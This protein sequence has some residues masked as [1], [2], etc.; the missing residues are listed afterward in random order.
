M[1]ELNGFL[2]GDKIQ[3][4]ERIPDSDSNYFSVAPGIGWSNER[5]QTLLAY[6]RILTGTNTD[7][8]DSVVLTFVYAF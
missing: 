1:L 3:D 7:A 4:G 2:Q 6:Q 8:N 5:M